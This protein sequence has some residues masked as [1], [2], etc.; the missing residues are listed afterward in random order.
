L[1]IKRRA[2]Q[3]QVIFVY[4]GLILFLPPGTN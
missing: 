3:E 4:R 2:F 1:A